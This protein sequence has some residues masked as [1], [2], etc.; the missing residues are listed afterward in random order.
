MKIPL[1]WLKEYVDLPPKAADLAEM[2]TMT[3]TKVEAVTQKN[4]TDILDLEI[5]TNRPDCLSLTGVAAEIAAVTGRKA[6]ARVPR[7]VKISDKERLPLTIE[8]K[9]KLG[10]PRYLG[11]AFTGASVKASPAWLERNLDWM[12]Q[13]PVNNVVD[14]TNFCLYELGQPLHAFDY[15]KIR[16]AK[17]VVRRAK[18]GEKITA[19]DGK[20]YALDERILVIADAVRPIAVAGVM[21]G[22][23]TE[24]TASTK[25]IVLESAQ[26]DPILIRRA[27]RLLKLASESSYRFERSVDPRHVKEA[28]DRASEMLVKLAGAV[29]ASKLIEA[30]SFKPPKGTWIRLRFERINTL[31]GV[32]LKRALMIRI[33]ASL[34]FKVKKGG[35]VELKVK[36]LLQRKDIRNESDLI[37]EIVRIYGF[38]KIPEAIPST[39]HVLRPA[40]LE[41]AAIRRLK[42]FLAA[43]GFY[44]A[45]TLS[46]QSQKFLARTG[47]DPSQAVKV[48]NPMSAEQEILRP[49]GFGG[50]LQVLSHNVSRKEKDLAF[51]EVGKRFMNDA[52]ENVLSI[53]VTGA[54]QSTWEAKQES[55][56]YYLKGVVESIFGFLNKEI[57]EWAE[58]T[59]PAFTEHAWMKIGD[60][61]IAGCGTVKPALAAEWDLKQPVYYAEIK[62]DAILKAPS[63]KKHFQAL[64][65]FPPVKR[66][67]AFLVPLQTSVRDIEQVMREAGGAT[68]KEMVLFDQYRGSN[69]PKGKRSLAFSLE[70]QKPD[71]TFTDDEIR[72]IHERVGHALK[73]QLG[74]ELR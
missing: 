64:P 22:K 74:A 60:E 34:G 71:G 31:L 72:Q 8:I 33:L 21:G 56:F 5:T 24:V 36:T 25:R 57:P 67:I 3:G 29:P 17:I 16:G 58:M 54:V 50:L 69:I 38:D 65:K 42:E 15:D 49:S 18:K 32:R 51:F 45:V 11:R 63:V 68:L 7:E 70:Y 10:C 40:D 46:L 52:E 47:W 43:Q 62:L 2:L 9:D 55:S 26:F 6:A 39:R 30:G 73:S 59:V 12:D 35:R 23:D 48:K 19:I 53:A 1:K 28:S 61:V 13:K 14:I 66:D 27:S 20:E 41:Y 4:G 37:E 44:E